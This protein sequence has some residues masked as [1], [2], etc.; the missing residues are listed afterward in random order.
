MLI[1]GNGTT[2]IRNT[3]NIKL[4]IGG[5]NTDILD[6][7]NTNINVYR[8]ILTDQTSFTND[9]ELIT[10]KYVDD[11][12]SGG[13]VAGPASSTDNA[14]TRF[15]GTTGKIIQNSNAT[16]DDTG[17]INSVN[18]Q[19]RQILGNCALGYNALPAMVNGAD[20][21]IIGSNA[22]LNLNG[23]ENTMVGCFAGNS[24]TTGFQNIFIGYSA[25]YGV[26]GNYNIIMGN[27]SNSTGNSSTVIGRQINNSAS[28]VVVLGEATKTAIYNAGNGV[29]DLGTASNKFKDIH[30]GGE[31]IG[32]PYDVMFAATDE[33]NAITTTGQKMEIRCPRSFQTSKIKVSVNVANTNTGFQ[34][35][36]KKNGVL[37]QTI[38]Q[39][40]FL[41]TNTN[42][43]TTYNEDDIISV[44]VSNVGNSNS[45]GLKVY[46]IGKTV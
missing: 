17:L 45:T 12:A 46:L 37:V 40:V 25:G 8:H 32:M 24:L 7:N 1:R 14:I 18:I 43:T 42:N 11:N 10:K 33:V 26:V 3:N 2:E 9:Q 13:D 28:N 4:Q 20:N 15:N 36:I 31:I 16:V 38:A 35:Q 41:I 44:E 6:V 5:A 23:Q 22:G 29:C 19:T 34:I 30:L 21:C 27:N 39:S